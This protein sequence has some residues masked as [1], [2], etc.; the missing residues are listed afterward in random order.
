[1]DQFD[2]EEVAQLQILYDL[3]EIVKT[4]PKGAESGGGVQAPGQKCGGAYASAPSLNLRTKS[5]YL[6][7]LYTNIKN[8]QQF[9]FTICSSILHPIASKDT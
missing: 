1:M 8:L 9:L 4:Y 2:F 6:L 7:P 5:L 3:E